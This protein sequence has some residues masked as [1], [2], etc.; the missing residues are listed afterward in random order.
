MNL[1]RCLKILELENPGSIEDAKRAYRDLVRVW[2]PDRFPGNTRLK[3][4]AEQKLREINLAFNYLR[5]YLESNRARETASPI[6]TPSKSSSEIKPASH[7]ARQASHNTHTNTHAMVGTHDTKPGSSAA[8]ARKS[9]AG[10]T[11]L[12]RFV[13]IT[14]FLIAV[15]ISAL[16]VYFITTTDD[17]T[18][19]ARGVASETVESILNK[20]EQDKTIQKNKPST[21]GI[22][23][24]KKSN[25]STTEI[26]LHLDSGSII[27]TDMWWEE[28][29]MIMYRVD[30]GTMGIERSRVKKI[31]KR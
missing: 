8:C 19:K 10:T 2:H 29:E 22:F 20:L 5:E 1:Q 18:S 24:D 11:S 12:G 31:V 16:A 4:K 26:E 17:I 7:A 6:N 9:A 27:M 30:G 28:G 23:Q 13:L 14:V 15:F 3:Q 25:N 21:N